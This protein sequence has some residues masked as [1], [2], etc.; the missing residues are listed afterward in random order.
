MGRVDVGRPPSA[1]AARTDPLQ[2]V[3]LGLLVTV[4]LVWDPRAGHPGSRPKYVVL[5]VGG[6]ALG[7][8]LALRPSVLS[9]N[10]LRWPVLAL[11]ASTVVSAAA[12]AHPRTA[13]RGFPGSYDGLWA[14]LAFGAVFFAAAA[15]FSE[16][17]QVR[18]ALTVLWFGAGTVVL[19][20]GTAQVAD[21][22]VAPGGWDWGR[23]SVSPRTIGSTLGNPN[24][25][26]A[27][28]AVLLPI[29]VVLGALGG[30]RVRLALAATGALAVAQ[31][32]ITS[33]R[34]GLLAALAGL[35]TLAVLLRRQLSP[36]R[37]PLLA[38][39]SG[40]LALALVAALAGG[41][42][43]VSKRGL[44]S[45]GTMGAGST[46]DLRREVWSAA[47]RVA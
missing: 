34:G 30:P 14:A 46:A 35:A 21:R 32:G 3:V 33:S 10:R 28:L 31:L 44:G 19:A 42:A 5:L 18:R 43:G 8:L 20:F 2:L 6:V 24:D 40:A 16:T 1:R 13:L 41:A 9:G 26:A 15:A 36:Y 22:L 27:F 38:V 17:R 11:L 23:P 4:P 39:V 47:W 29:G 12:S 37:A 7:G 25:V 45:V